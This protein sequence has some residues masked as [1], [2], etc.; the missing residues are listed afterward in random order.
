MN[1]Q[2]TPR[3][4]DE[5]A[6]WFMAT[7]ANGLKILDTLAEGP[8]T[9]SEIRERTGL[10][11]SAAY[12][13]VR[14]LEACGYLQ[15]RSFD[16]RLQIGNRVWE[17]GASVQRSVEVSEVAGQ[18][19]RRLAAELGESVHLAVYDSGHVV[20]IDKADG[21]NPVRSYTR[22]GGRAPSY[23]VATGKVMLSHQDREEIERVVAAGLTPFTQRTIT[24]REKLLHELR[25]V[26]DRGVAINHDE[27]RDG[28]SG[29][30]VPIHEFGGS[31]IAA[32]GFSGPTARILPSITILETAL[33]AAAA[34]VSSELGYI[35]P[36]HIT[37]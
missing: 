18:V 3:A 10:E 22:L 4:R 8:L 25:E 6:P 16:G 36:R 35:T 24:D 28:V 11:R 17:I 29:L 31:I 21:S 1:D 5:D 7:L 32:L 19:V 26:R 12:R 34:E 33:R 2:D 13:L 20:Y 23:C 27:W 9:V 15:R 37:N 14:T 30:A